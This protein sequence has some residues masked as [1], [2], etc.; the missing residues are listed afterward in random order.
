MAVRYNVCPYRTMKKDISGT[1]S[2]LNVEAESTINTS[3]YRCF[4]EEYCPRL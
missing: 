4:G 1:I 2:T 3:I